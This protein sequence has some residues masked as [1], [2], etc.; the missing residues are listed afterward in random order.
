MRK[1]S[2]ALWIGTVGVQLG[3][4]LTQLLGS[5]WISPIS[6][7]ATMRPAMGPRC[8]AAACSCASLSA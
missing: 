2:D 7:S 3:F 4:T 1:P 8:S 6:T 5:L